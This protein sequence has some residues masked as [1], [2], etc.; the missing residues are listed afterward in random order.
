MKVAWV[1]L[2]V[3]AILVGT[4]LVT[5]M[6]ARSRLLDDLARLEIV[7]IVAHLALYGALT[8][9]GLHAGLS[10]RRAAALTLGVAVVQEGVQIG[11]AGR[12]PGLPEL[13]DLGVDTV[14]IALVLFLAGHRKVVGRRHAAPRAVDERQGT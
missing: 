5:P 1:G 8:A 4:A 11:L 7:H 13:F 12:A 10:A 9:L 2:W 6:T 14:A 3:V